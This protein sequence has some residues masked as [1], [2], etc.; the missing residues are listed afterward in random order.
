MRRF[1]RLAAIFIVADLSAALV[2]T[3]VL[4]LL[5]AAGVPTDNVAL[6]LGIF[7]VAFLAAWYGIR[8]WLRARA[9]RAARRG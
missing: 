3:L 1:L 2:A 6:D 4:L 9:S 5:A 8:R 7:A